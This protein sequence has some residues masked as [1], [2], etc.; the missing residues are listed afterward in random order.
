MLIDASPQYTKLHG[1]FKQW[2]DPVLDVTGLWQGTWEL[3]GPEPDHV[4]VRVGALIRWKDGTKTIWYQ[5]NWH[6]LHS[7]QKA[8]AFREMSY[9][10]NLWRDMNSAA[11]EPFCEKLAEIESAKSGGEI[12][13][14][15]LFQE[16]DVILEPTR[17]NWRAAYGPPEYSRPTPFY[18][19]LA[20]E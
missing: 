10:D 13:S 17:E 14:M 20:N 1:Q 7:W 18:R 9:Y 3:F 16:R 12:Q 6:E 4:N 5:P 19:W 8:R 15:D 2:I 11:W